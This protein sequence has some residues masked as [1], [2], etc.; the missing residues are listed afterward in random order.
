M[1]FLS[2]DLISV[3]KKESVFF[4]LMQFECLLHFQTVFSPSGLLSI[5]TQLSAPST[6]AVSTG[7]EAGEEVG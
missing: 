7:S 3:P 1:L 5:Q 6:A 2:Y 4:Q